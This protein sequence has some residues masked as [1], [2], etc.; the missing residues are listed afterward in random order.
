MI[1]DVPW[2][3][4]GEG[5]AMATGWKVKCMRI[6]AGEARSRDSPR[7]LCVLYACVKQVGLCA[8]Y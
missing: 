8:T 4:E 6:G 7:D 3:G 2:E 5:D 1:E